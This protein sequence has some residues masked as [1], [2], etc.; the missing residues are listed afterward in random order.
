MTLGKSWLVQIP[1]AGCWFHSLELNQIS[2]MYPVQLM[3]CVQWTNISFPNKIKQYSF[4][5]LLLHQ[6]LKIPLGSQ[7]IVCTKEQKLEFQKEKKVTLS[8]VKI[9]DQK[10][11]HLERFFLCTQV[12]RNRSRVVKTPVRNP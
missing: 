3:Q 5:W 8:N 1:L 10:R 11:F 7:T 2:N 9:S 6:N 12:L 4:S